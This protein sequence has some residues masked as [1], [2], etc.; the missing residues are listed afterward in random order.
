M[1]KNV[2]LFIEISISLSRHPHIFHQLSFNQS[3]HPFIRFSTPFLFI[4]CF[5]FNSP[6]T[7][8]NK[9]LKS[10]QLELGLSWPRIN[11]QT[12]RVLIELSL[13]LPAYHTGMIA[14]NKQKQFS[15]LT[16]LVSVFFTFYEL[17]LVYKR[18]KPRRERKK[19]SNSI[20]EQQVQNWVQTREPKQMERDDAQINEKCFQNALG[21]ITITT[22]FSWPSQTT[23]LIEQP[24][25][26]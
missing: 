16:T 20:V 9:H 5:C 25:C 14:A 15:E 24:K 1:S 17:R 6:A 7:W 2:C 11:L 12:S 18:N 19:R 3:I 26:N 23:S 4:Y 13:D 10:Y 22:G 8:A 21:L